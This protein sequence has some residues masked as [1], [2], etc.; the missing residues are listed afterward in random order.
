MK[1]KIGDQAR[2][3]KTIT[4]QD[5]R[6]FAELSGDKNSVHLDPEFA[7]NTIFKGVIAHGLYIASFISA[8]L[9][10]QLPGPG[11][12]YLNQELKFTKPAYIGDDVTAEVTV[13][14]FPKPS[15]VKLKTVCYN[16]NNDILIDGIAL[17]KVL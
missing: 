8:I 12:I 4:A 11:S 1:F 14:E 16:Q 15:L 6:M 13:L 17:I 7:K 10:N 9:G 5:I 3:T 2:L